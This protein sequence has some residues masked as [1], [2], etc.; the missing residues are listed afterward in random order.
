MHDAEFGH[1]VKTMCALVSECS[2]P[3]SLLS[4]ELVCAELCNWHGML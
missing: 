1:F 4:V 2:R 3:L